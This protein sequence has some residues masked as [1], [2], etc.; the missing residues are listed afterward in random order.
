MRTFRHALCSDHLVILAFPFRG[1]VSHRVWGEGP[2]K[3]DASAGPFEVSRAADVRL[4]IEVSPLSV[5]PFPSHS[6]IR[7]SLSLSLSL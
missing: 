6:F 4:I 3:P 1:R 2:W 5:L 7:P